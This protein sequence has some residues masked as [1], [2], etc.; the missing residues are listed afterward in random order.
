MCQ[1]GEVNETLDDINQIKPQMEPLST[2]IYA[3]ILSIAGSLR[4][5]TMT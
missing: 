4:N 5:S 2:Q 3:S 1:N